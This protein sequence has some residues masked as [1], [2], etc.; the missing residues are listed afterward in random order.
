[1]H[2]SRAHQTRVFQAA[3]VFIQIASGGEV[4]CID[5]WPIITPDAKITAGYISSRRTYDA[6]SPLT[7][8]ITTVY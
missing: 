5:R 8:G 4:L 2:F 3:H 6:E 7:L 1:M